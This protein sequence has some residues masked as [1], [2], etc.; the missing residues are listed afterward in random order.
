MDQLLLLKLENIMS[1]SSVSPFF[2]ARIFLIGL[3]VS[4]VEGIIRNP[5]TS[6]FKWFFLF[7]VMVYVAWQHSIINQIEKENEKGHINRLK[8]QETVW[9]YIAL[10]QVA[11]VFI[12]IIVGVPHEVMFL[13]SNIFW[14]LVLYFE[15]IN[16]VKPPPKRSTV[17]DRLHGFA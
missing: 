7:V 16:W 11:W 12:M 6:S 14:V 1:R 2:L 8:F 4:Y 17:V 13:V 15:A 5:I 10:F 3:M 9:R